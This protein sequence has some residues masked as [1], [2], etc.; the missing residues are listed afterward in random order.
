MSDIKE[1][2]K[3]SDYTDKDFYR[4]MN[5]YLTAIYKLKEATNSLKSDVETRIETYNIQ[6]DNAKEFSKIM[7]LYSDY[8]KKLKLYI[9]YVKFKES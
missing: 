2:I 9:P 3:N 6:T 8:V 5:N 1:F 4:I 7:S